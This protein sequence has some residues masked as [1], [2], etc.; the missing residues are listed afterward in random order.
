MRHRIYAPQPFSVGEFVDVT[1]D[2]FHHAARVVRVKEGEE[3]ELFDG[4]GRAVR[5]KVVALERAQLRVR[6]DAEVPARELPIDLCLAMSIIQLDK[7]ELVL[8]KATELGVQS[9]IPTVSERVELR[10]E[11]Y[12]GK[13]QRWEK[14]VF[15]AVKQSG[16]SVIPSIDAPAPLEQVVTRPGVKIIFDADRESVPLPATLAAAMLLIGPEGGWT[17]NELDV[18]RGAGCLS[19][20]LGSRRLRA[21]TAAIV[22]TAVISARYGDI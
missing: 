5:G 1:A 10:P 3:V 13:Q 16:R 12:R 7:F 18:A 17:E 4:R 22:A 9:F 14:V 19:R 6:V 20:R 2:E 11:R 15:E 8:Q 21:E